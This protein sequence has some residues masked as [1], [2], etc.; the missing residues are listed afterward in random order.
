M[1]NS[2][3]KGI[4]KATT[5]AKKIYKSVKKRATKPKIGLNPK[6]PTSSAIQKHNK[7]LKDA[8]NFNSSPNP[9]LKKMDK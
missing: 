9:S 1:A 2:I 6:H 8:L 4:N 5:K 7:A 3:T